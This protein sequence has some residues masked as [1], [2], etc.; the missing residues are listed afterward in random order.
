[1]G[2]GVEIR[3]LA[4]MDVDKLGERGGKAEEVTESTAVEK[5]KINS[6][7]LDISNKDDDNNEEVSVS[8]CTRVGLMN[9]EE[10]INCINV[11]QN[12]PVHPAKH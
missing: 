3:L 6:S 2:E 9:S 5:G 1:M 8:D 12:S 4:K 10:V 11:S 7:E